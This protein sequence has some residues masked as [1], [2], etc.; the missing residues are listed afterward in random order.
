MR[1]YNPEQIM[2]NAVVRR[3]SRDVN[4]MKEK[5]IF[6]GARN[7][8]THVFFMCSS[9]RFKGIE[10]GDQFVVKGHSRFKQSD[11][12]KI[13]AY[14]YLQWNRYYSSRDIIGFESLMFELGLIL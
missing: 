10:Y 14:F 5:L 12:H 1:S 11:K 6:S 3:P 8:Q 7:K 9:Q 4:I 13:T 2:L